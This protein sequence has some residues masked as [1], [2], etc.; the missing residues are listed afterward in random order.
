MEGPKKPP[1]AYVPFHL[2]VKSSQPQDANCRRNEL[3]A[4]NFG[5]KDST[6]SATNHVFKQKFSIFVAD[7]YNNKT[8]KTFFI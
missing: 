3:F 6:F 7:F 8:E 4:N 5:C 1:R 2:A